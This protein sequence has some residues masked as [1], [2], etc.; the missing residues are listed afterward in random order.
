MI[1]QSS[2]FSEITTPRRVLTMVKNERMGGY[3]PKWDTPDT[4]RGQVEQNLSL[5]EHGI[6]PAQPDFSAALAYHGGGL[7]HPAAQRD[8]FTFG[9]LVDMVNPLHHIPVVGSVYREVTGDEI[10]PIG[11]IIGGGVFGGPLGAASGLVNAVVEE[12]TGADLTE[13]A[14]AMVRD[15]GGDFLSSRSALQAEE[16]LEKAQDAVQ[17]ADDLSASL[18]S[19]TDHGANVGYRADKFSHFKALH[20]QSMNADETQR[21][22]SLDSMPD[23]PTREPI[24]RLR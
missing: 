23:L 19:F 10:K 15:G 16:R 14:I 11:K 12:E 20:K 8:E 3:V 7:A 17:S 6:D 1:E 13:N 4:A 2:S 22:A 18:L 24:T 5:A 9:D 21:L